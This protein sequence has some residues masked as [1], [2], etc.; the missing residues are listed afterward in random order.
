MQTEGRYETESER[1]KVLS[2]PVR[3]QL[4][5]ELR[6]A[7]ACVCHLQAV[8]DRPQAYVSQ[9]LAV[10]RDADVVDTSKDGLNVFYHLVDHKIANV[11]E[12]LLGPAGAPRQVNGCPCPKCETSDADSAQ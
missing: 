5:N 10:M 4:L 2:H 1:C 12:I 8:V 6:R 7:E 9:Q 11:L 3:L